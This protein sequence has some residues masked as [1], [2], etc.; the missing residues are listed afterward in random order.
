MS[1]GDRL[2]EER[3]RLGLKQ[4]DFASKVGSDVAKQSLYENNRREL[5]ADY[6]AR[7]AEAGVDV[8]Y[9]L[10]GERG[11]GAWL[12]AGAS[13]LLSAYFALPPD[14]QQALL[15]FAQTL[16]GQFSRERSRTVHSKTLDFRS[17]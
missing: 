12:G 10:T 3:K 4:Q 5:R 7:V 2:A 6:L 17:E 11:Q 8:V 9:I 13:E 1:F 14:M 15:T 16:S